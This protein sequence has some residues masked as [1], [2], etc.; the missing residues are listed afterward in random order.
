MESCFLLILFFKLESK[1]LLKEEY[2]ANTS[3][4]Y[5]VKINELLNNISDLNNR[6]KH[7]EILII[8]KEEQFNTIC[9]T[10]QRLETRIVEMDKHLL[11][12]M[13]DKEN[14][15][16]K[17]YILQVFEFYAF[18]RKELNFFFN[19]YRMIIHIFLQL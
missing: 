10:K 13:V 3:L 4:N 17:L 11:E 6:L 15:E 5:Q 12:I 16:Q 8:E 2:C 14:I 18:N 9:D 7:S 1:I 19:I